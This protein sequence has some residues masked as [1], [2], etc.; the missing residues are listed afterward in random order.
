MISAFLLANG[1][2]L[3]AGT[4]LVYPLG[5]SLARILVPPMAYLVG[6]GAVA[7]Q[8]LLYSLFK[9][10]WEILYLAAPWLLVSIFFGLTQRKR[11]TQSFREIASS[12][13]PKLDVVE[14][15]LCLLV[16]L[17]FL[18]LTLYSFLFSSAL[19]WDGMENWFFK[20]KAFYLDGGITEKFLNHPFAYY[21]GFEGFNDTYY[22]S[23]YPVFLP[24][25]VAWIYTFIAGVHEFWGKLLWVIF[26]GN[27]VWLFAVAGSRFGHKK[28][29]LL[30]LLLTFSAR[31]VF[32]HLSILYGG[33][34]DLPLAT[35]VLA[36]TVIWLEWKKSNDQRLLVLSLILASIGA[37]IKDDGKVFL[38]VMF[39]LSRKYLLAWVPILILLPWQFIKWQFGLHSYLFEQIH[40]DYVVK[41]ITAYLTMAFNT[42]R[43]YFAG[44]LFMVTAVIAVLKRN[45]IAVWI[46]VLVGLTVCGYMLIYIFTPLDI[47]RHLES[48]VDRLLFHVYPTAMLVPV[49][50]LS[51]LVRDYQSA[52]KK[53]YA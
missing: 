37:M 23:S 10:P 5:K 13:I 19:G 29:A 18:H 11:I 31:A 30:L 53:P 4:I 44:V 22:F 27:L 8:M 34:A 15:I 12:K 36:S 7:M 3:L 6:W 40:I 38:L 39:V 49:I 24:L 26:L 52:E 43:F 25:M 9:I 2:S 33:Y 47:N 41:S 28:I 48:S 51:K 20:A 35:Y 1:I 16:V 42:N 46:S 14:W 17:L 45:L 50:V 21:E 32:N